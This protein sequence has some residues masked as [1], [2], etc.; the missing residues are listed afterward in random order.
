MQDDESLQLIS[1]TP[2]LAESAAILHGITDL[3]I[4]CL[5]AFRDSMEFVEWVR[6]AID[7]KIWMDTFFKKIFCGIDAGR[8]A[9][10]VF[11]RLMELCDKV[12]SLTLY[13]I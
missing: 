10:L 7:G 6:E 4:E 13:R 5:T 2:A 3:Q 12:F 11:E 1:L 8:I 9:E